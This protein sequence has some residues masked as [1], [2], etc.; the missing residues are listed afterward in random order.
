MMH[1]QVRRA[2]AAQGHVYVYV[3]AAD[4][5]SPLDEECGSIDYNLQY[6]WE[7]R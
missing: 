4:C 6:G 3:V 7:T 1:T 5:C 2:H